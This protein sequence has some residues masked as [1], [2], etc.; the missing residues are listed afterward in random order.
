MNVTIKQA[1]IE[2]LD[3]VAELFDGYRQFYQQPSD[4]EVGKAFLRQRL[5]HHE[6]VIFLATDEAGLGLGFTQLYPTFS[7]VSLQPRWILNDLFVAE[8]ARKSGVASQ[9][10]Q[11]AEDFAKDSGASGLTLSTAVDNLPAQALYKR[12]GW[13]KATAF[14]NYNKKVE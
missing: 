4:V 9:L 3:I 8:S 11:A 1:G 13:S 12:R 2:D 6:S 5:Q 7:S 10:M 14:C